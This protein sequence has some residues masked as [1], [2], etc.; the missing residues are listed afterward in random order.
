MCFSNCAYD[1]KHVDLT[2]V[3]SRKHLKDAFLSDL[4]LISCNSNKFSNKKYVSSC[5][6]FTDK[7]DKHLTDYVLA[8]SGHHINIHFRQRLCS[9]EVQHRLSFIVLVGSVREISDAPP[10]HC[11]S[12][13]MG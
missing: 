8:Y 2:L 7:A 4:P 5:I 1:N 10:A 6:N 11:S 13:F 9:P 3:R 12:M